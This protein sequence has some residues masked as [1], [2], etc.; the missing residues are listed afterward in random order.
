MKPFVDAPTGT[1]PDVILVRIRNVITGM[2]SPA[3]GL[4]DGGFDPVPVAAMRFRVF[5]DGQ[6]PGCTS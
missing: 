6:P 4:T 5:I 3:V 1:L 2:S